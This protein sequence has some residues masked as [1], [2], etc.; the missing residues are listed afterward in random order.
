M[1][2]DMTAFEHVTALLSF[3]YALALTHLL[4]RISE[5]FVARD[6]VKFSGLLTLG[7][8]NAILVVFANWLSLWDFR[9]I[10]VWDLASITVNFL[11]AI[12]IFLICAL[13]GPKAHEEGAIDLE[14]F[15]WRQRPYFYGALVGCAFMSLLANLDFLKTANAALF[16]KENLT[17]LPMFIPTVAGMVSRKRWVQWAAGFCYLAMVLGYTIVFYSTLS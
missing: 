4:A 11:L 16:V 13:V 17:V 2:T 7:I 14:D 15:F 8:A 12:N 10:K 9:L 6:R 3:V 1:A 5:L